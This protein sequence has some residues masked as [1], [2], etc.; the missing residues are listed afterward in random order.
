[1]KTFNEKAVGGKYAGKT[2]LEQAKAEGFNVITTAAE[3]EKVTAADQKKPLLG[4]FDDGN[5]PTVLTGPQ[6]TL[7]GNLDKPAVKCEANPK[8]TADK[9]ELAAMTKT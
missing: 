9:P 4:L 5:M 1:M 6:A 3:L 8:H 2:L 7:H